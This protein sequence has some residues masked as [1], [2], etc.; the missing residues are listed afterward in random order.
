MLVV[1]LTPSTATAKNNPI[2]HTPGEIA[3]QPDYE[4]APERHFE[5]CG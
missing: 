2:D 4:P 5:A 1:H 3:P